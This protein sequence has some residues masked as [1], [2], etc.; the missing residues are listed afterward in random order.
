[1]PDPRRTER[2]LEPSDADERVVELD[3]LEDVVPPTD[4]GDPEVVPAPPPDPLTE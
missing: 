1:M 3:E 4:D 2:H